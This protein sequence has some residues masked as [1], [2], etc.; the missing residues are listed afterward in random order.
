MQTTKDAFID[1]ELRDE[2]YAELDQREA[3]EPWVFIEPSKKE[4]R[5][6]R[7]VQASSL[8]Y[9]AWKKYS[10]ADSNV[11]AWWQSIISADNRVK[12]PLLRDFAEQNSIGQLEADYNYL[13]F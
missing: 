6:T 11:F 13:R 2:Y 12:L 7:A 10:M 5:F 8:E 9:V 3:S 1:T 4:V